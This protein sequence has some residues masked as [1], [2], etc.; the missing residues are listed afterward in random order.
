MTVGENGC[1][2]NV[3]DID[4]NHASPKLLLPESFSSCAASVNKIMIVLTVFRFYHLPD[5]SSKARLRTGIFFKVW[6]QRCPDT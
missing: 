5:A 6:E 2:L 4:Y 3:V 1:C